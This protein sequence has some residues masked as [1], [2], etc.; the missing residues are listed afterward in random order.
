M[1]EIGQV[2]VHKLFGEGTI[3]SKKDNGEQSYI[4]VSFSEGEKKFA[5]PNAFKDF[6]KAKDQKFKEYIDE[7]ILITDKKNKEKKI[8]EEQVK[9]SFENYITY[10]DKKSTKKISKRKKPVESSSIAFK[11]NYCDGGRNKNRIGFRGACSLKLIRNNIFKEH[12][13]WCRQKEC[14]CFLFYKGEITRKELDEA[15]EYGGYVCYESQFL[16]EWTAYAGNHGGKPQPIK[17]DISDNLC[18]LTTRE[19][20]M[21]EKDRFIFAVFLVND[22]F[23]GNDYEEGHVSAHPKY[24]IELSPKEAKKMLFWKYHRNDNSSDRMFWGS[25]LVR[26]L[27]DYQAAQ[28]L[29]DVARIKKGS[30]QERLANEFFHYYCKIHGINVDKIGKPR[31]A[32]YIHNK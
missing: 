10:E 31:G 15:C 9:D 18:V 24:R 11:C 3:C 7:L 6:L 5:F 8:K 12:R 19:P 28:I 21:H 14:P 13:K 1:N 23:R 4:M 20:G 30:N 29:R 27:E 26:Y 32:L 22:Y 2:V 17:K 25:G 16:R